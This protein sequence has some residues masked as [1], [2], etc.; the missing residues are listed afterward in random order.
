MPLSI[1][2]LASTE[3]QSV[4][5]STFLKNLRRTAGKQLKSAKG[6]EYIRKGLLLSGTF[7]MQGGHRFESCPRYNIDRQNDL[8]FQLFTNNSNNFY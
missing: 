7:C 2:R 1:I 5:R 6:R 4:A 3:L 8:F